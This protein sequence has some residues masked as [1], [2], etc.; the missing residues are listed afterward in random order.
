MNG[1]ADLALVAVGRRRVDVAV[2]GA[3]RGLDCVA[4]FVG[5]SLEDPETE[6][7]H[8]DTIVEG[9]GFHGSHSAWCDVAEGC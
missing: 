9:Q 4:G 1:L 7:W 3:E 5:R 2:T 8:L 6:R